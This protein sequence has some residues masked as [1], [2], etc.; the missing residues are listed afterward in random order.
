MKLQ[1]WQ[2]ILLAYGV[3]LVLAETEAGPLASLM[4]WGVAVTYFVDANITQGNLI[5]NLF[6]APAAVTPA[7][8]AAQTQQGQQ[9]AGESTG[10]GGQ[11]TGTSPNTVLSSGG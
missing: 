2:A 6:A 9:L 1:E 3:L 7:Q 10:L 4:A 8:Q 5:S 11:G